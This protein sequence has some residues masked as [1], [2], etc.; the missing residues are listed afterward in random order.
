MENP[1]GNSFLD[2]LPKKTSWRN[3]NINTVFSSFLKEVL[4]PGTRLGNM[5]T[6]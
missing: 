3:L 1:S 4:P 5:L 6:Q 2:T